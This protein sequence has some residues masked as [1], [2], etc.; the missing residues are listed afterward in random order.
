MYGCMFEV[1]A[2]LPAQAMNRMSACCVPLYETLGE[3]AIEYILEHS[4]SKLII[5]VVSSGAGKLLA[6]GVH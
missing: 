1:C 2:S 3:N 4:G 5:S 6:V